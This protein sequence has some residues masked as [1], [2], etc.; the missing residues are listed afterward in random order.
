[1]DL[2]KLEQQ[3]RAMTEHLDVDTFIYKL[4][5]L[6]GFPKASITRLKKGD[7]NQL[8]QTNNKHQDLLWKKRLLFKVEQQDLHLSI[9][10][11]QKDSLVLKQHPRFIIQYLRH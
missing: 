2:N 3:I 8:K 9:D 1:M 10:D 7:Y 11:A 6:Y 5:L 4:L